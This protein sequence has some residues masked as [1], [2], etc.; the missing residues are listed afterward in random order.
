[1]DYMKTWRTFFDN[2]IILLTTAK[3]GYFKFCFDEERAN[4]L[5]SNANRCRINVRSFLLRHLSFVRGM[6]IYIVTF[7]T[8]IQKPS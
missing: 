7:F 3:P 1:M 5:F 8:V 2:H 6:R 4:A